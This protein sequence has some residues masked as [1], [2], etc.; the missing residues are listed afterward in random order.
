MKRDINNK[1]RNKNNISIRIINNVNTVQK[2][3]KYKRKRAKKE[4]LN[5]FNVKT[6]YPA[7]QAWHLMRFRPFNQNNREATNPNIVQYQMILDQMK[8]NEQL[9]LTEREKMSEKM[10]LLENK[11]QEREDE[12]PYMLLDGSPYDEQ[13]EDIHSGRRR[14]VRVGLEDTIDK[15]RRGSLT[16]TE[17]G[18]LKKAEL[19]EIFEELGFD[20]GTLTVKGAKEELYDYMQDIKH[21]SQGQTI[22]ERF[23][24]PMSKKKS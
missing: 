6:Q 13:K 22:M 8:K 16:K 20:Y 12:E 17:L 10:L 1:N 7:H 5:R 14:V 9:Q 21:P 11:I 15:I 2:R 18:R 3:R 23:F 4:T 24:T 19:E